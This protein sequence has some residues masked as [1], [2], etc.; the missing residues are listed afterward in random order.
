MK[1]SFLVE[2]Y[3]R[4]CK[5]T[6]R[7]EKTYYIA[8]LIKQTPTEELEQILLLLEGR[9]FHPWEEAKI[10]M[11]SRLV[12]KAI[13]VASGM[14]LDTVEKEWKHT[15][16]LGQTAHN[17]MAK[18]KQSTLFSR[19]LTVTKVFTNLR[20]IAEL[21]GQGTVDKKIQY[22]TELLTSAQPLEA[23]YI[24]RTV[25][26]EL[27]VGAGSGSVRD[28]I[29]WSSFPPVEGIV[30]RCEPCRAWMP[31]PHCLLCKKAL[32]TAGT[33]T[34]QKMKR[35]EVTDVSLLKRLEKY[36]VIIPDTEEKAR[37]IYNYLLTAVEEAY[38]ST[39]TFGHVVQV[40]REKGIEGLQKIS[41]ELGKPLKA[42][43]YQKAHDVAEAFE[44][45]GKPC[46]F[47]YKYD[48]F[49]LLIHKDKN[50]ITLFTR[51]FEKVSEQFPDVV[52]YVK[53]YVSADTCILDSEAVG[54]ERKT[55]RYLPF[56]NISQRIKRKY[57][58]KE[59]MEKFPVE[60]NVFDILY[61]NGKTLLKVPF[62]ERRALLTKI[63]DPVERKIVPSRIIITDAVA[64]ANTFYHEALDRG[65][66]GVMAKNLNALY[67]PGSRVGYGVKIKPT[68]ES[69]DLV[70]VGA[71]W[72]EGKRSGWL[73][74]FTVACVDDD[75]NFV[76]LGRVG[77]GIK[78]L[79]AEGLTFQ[80]LTELLTPLISSEK[81][82]EVTV[83]P[84]IV[85]EI[86]Y[87]EIQK[88][89][90]YSS[91]YALRFPR[92]VR[93]RED[94]APEDCSTLEQVEELYDGQ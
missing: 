50:K 90:T 68:M 87:E 12:L 15:G 16:D 56:Q 20:K 51:R 2:M 26:E 3:E 71:E 69:L 35:L 62:H 86:T 72:G 76:E 5:T 34:T 91:G 32:D 79:E 9:V 81:G 57:N 75:G 92:V 37:E 46:A 63:I 24:I 6:K 33:A 80:Q 19:E 74:S 60:V 44:R 11:A 31:P 66:E 49:R 1:Y 10:G 78:E 30:Y 67:K 59:L 88:S 85:I 65:N 48:G 4:L 29:V 38:N 13:A 22:C 8:E 25:L 84:K 70:I 39:N 53:K 47:E 21:E 83:R 18:K 94:R 45:V 43:L 54:Y 14:P 36:D 41:L 64:T 28:A 58:I 52:E 93:L 55:T 23:K 89:P 7:L 73:T 61:C 17:F 42:M 77:T 82:R 40:I 27:R